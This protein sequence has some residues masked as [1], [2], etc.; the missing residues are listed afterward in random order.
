MGDIVA[1]IVFLA[2]GF[3]HCEDRV[4]SVCEVL[5]EI[6]GDGGVGA[7]FNGGAFGIEIELED[8]EELVVEAFADGGTDFLHDILGDV[9]E[10][11]DVLSDVVE[12]GGPGFRVA[13]WLVLEGVTFAEIFADFC[14]GDD[15]EGVVIVDLVVMCGDGIGE[16]DEGDDG[17]IVASP[18]FLFDDVGDG[19]DAGA[20]DVVVPTAGIGI[21]DGAV[22][23]GVDVFGEGAAGDA[24]DGVEQGSRSKYA[25]ARFLP[26]TGA[27][28]AGDGSGCEGEAAEE[29]A[30]GGSTHGCLIPPAVSITGFL[31]PMWNKK[32]DWGAQVKQGGAQILV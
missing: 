20:E 5:K 14:L 30:V 13:G 7:A 24:V 19:V 1:L 11:L 16:A 25:E 3:H 10:I 4:V 28:D 12:K 2:E 21:G 18:G 27:G 15:G 22:E 23:D 29:H 31:F 17:G 9:G 8:L 32:A 6:E 26:G